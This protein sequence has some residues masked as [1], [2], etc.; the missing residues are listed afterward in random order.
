MSRVYVFYATLL[1]GEYPQTPSLAELPNGCF[2]YYPSD[3]YFHQHWYLQD[4]TPV[5]PEDVPKE[6]KTLVL[7]MGI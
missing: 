3:P 6:L 2:L 5:L 4:M 7:L 1:Y